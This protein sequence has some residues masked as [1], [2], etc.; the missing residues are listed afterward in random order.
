MT[1]NS[2]LFDFDKQYGEYIT[3]TDEAGRGPGAGPVYAA[4]VCFREIN[5][6][7]L[8]KLELLNDS[9]KLSEKCREELFEIITNCS[10]YSIQ[11]SSVEDIEK[12]NILNASLDAMKR[13]C[14]EVSQKTGKKSNIILVDGNK[15]IKNYTAQQITVIK[16]DSKSA[17]IAA[18]SILA[19][20]SRDRFMYELDKKFPQ[21]NWAKNK[22][23]LTAE[24]IEAI[25]NNGITV[26][27]RKKFLRNIL[28]EEQKQ[29][30]LL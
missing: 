21:Y 4:A 22:G 30:S 6:S 8:K 18:A 1:K 10:V 15:K 17:A 16:G 11:Y 28:Q 2:S 24:H 7:V 23:Y 29:L 13:A 12:K 25:K 9:K 14:E 27:H 20:V 19:K 3:G 26:W 5:E